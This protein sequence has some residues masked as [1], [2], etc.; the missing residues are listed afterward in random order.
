MYEKFGV[1]KERERKK[2]GKRIKYKEEE[3]KKDAKKRIKQKKECYFN[4]A[5]ASSKLRG[6]KK[7]IKNGFFCPKWHEFQ[8]D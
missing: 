8:L 6:K 1:K 3:W 5:K 7:G 2:S 4:H